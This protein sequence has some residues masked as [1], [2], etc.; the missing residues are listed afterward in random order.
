MVGTRLFQR[1]RELCNDEPGMRLN[2]IGKEF[3]YVSLL[4]AELNAQEQKC[5]D[6]PAA[7]QPI[8]RS[9]GVQQPP[10]SLATPGWHPLIFKK[11]PG[12]RTP[13][14]IQVGQ[15]QAAKLGGGI[16]SQ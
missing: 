8:Q 10:V 9:P 1:A 3:P 5:T 14:T 16:A 12:A 6:L 13:P 4:K 15:A 7:R 2:M 11:L